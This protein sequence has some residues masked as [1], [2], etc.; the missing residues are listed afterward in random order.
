MDPRDE[1]LT[2]FLQHQ[3]DLRAFIGSMLRERNTRDDV[4]QETA[5]VLWK[6]FDRYDR[7]RSF[8]AWARGIASNKVLQR[9]DRDRRIPQSLPAEAVPAVLASF[10]RTDIPG[11]ARREALEV[12]LQQLPDKSRALLKLRYEQGMSV[13]Q[14]A[15]RMTSTLDAIHKSLSRIR[16]KLQECVE[17][18][19]RIA[20]EA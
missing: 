8:G 7:S 14:L 4:L 15:E 13:A 16:A 2:L 6:E 11:D 9:L 5:L 20:G 17:R 12:C 3:S 10:E 1:F 19:L 18:R